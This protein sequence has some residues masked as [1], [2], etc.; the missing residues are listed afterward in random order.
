MTE[1]SFDMQKASRPGLEQKRVSVDFPK[2]MVHELD[3]V[4][5]KLG[6]TRQSIIKIFISDKLRE[7]KY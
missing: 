1:N 3:K 7:E 2:W 5:K 4:S 6:V